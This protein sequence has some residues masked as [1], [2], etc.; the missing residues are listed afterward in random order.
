[1]TRADLQAENEEYV[2]LMGEA[3]LVRQLPD[4]TEALLRSIARIKAVAKAVGEI[5]AYALAYRIE[6]DIEVLQRWCG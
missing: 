3:D 2:K 5:D 6:H 1:M 4:E